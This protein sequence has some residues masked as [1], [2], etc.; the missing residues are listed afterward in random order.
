MKKEDDAKMAWYL[1]QNHAW[2]ASFAPA[3]NPEIVVAVLV[4]HGGSGPEVA[5]PV[6]MQ[7]IHEYERLQA[8]RSRTS[9]V[10]E[11]AAGQAW[12]RRP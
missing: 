3:H 1:T 6:A 8:V 4:E 2:F 12:G 9:A 10:G 5:V 11:V 7:I